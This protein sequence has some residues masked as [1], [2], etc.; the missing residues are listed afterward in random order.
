MQKNNDTHPDPDLILKALGYQSA[1][2]IGAGINSV[3]Y[4]LDE[5]RVIKL[6][7][8]A[9]G[10]MAARKSFLDLLGSK[11]LPFHIPQILEY[12]EIQGCFY[13]IETLVPGNSLRVV[14]PGIHD[15]EKI[16]CIS[17][18]FDVLDA[19]HAVKVEGEF[20][21]QLC[22]KSGISD[23]T[24]RGFL[25]KKTSQQYELNAER[26]RRDFSD[27]EKVVAQFQAELSGLSESAPH[28]VVHGDVFFPNVMA[29]T[30]G[31]ITGI[32]DFSELTL[33]GDPFMDW[34]SLSIFVRDDEG[35]SLVHEMLRS[36]FGDAF[37]RY[38]RLYGMYYALRF[39]GCRDADP[40]TY[41]WCLREFRNYEN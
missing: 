34:V 1:R 35:R 19:L 20:G 4:Q 2:P 8:A 9:A 3:V 21:E 27:F 15:T 16:R 28:S 39:C 31:R 36:K 25:S 12:G 17:G 14:F 32:V 29:S 38:R 23:D 37:I 24:W 26:V 18:L 5:C 40:D 7:P 41:A 6:T 11:K 22:G 13:S 30:D 10:E 33:I